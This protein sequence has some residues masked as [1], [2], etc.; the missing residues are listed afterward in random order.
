MA[1][2][3]SE[4]LSR[5]ALSGWRTPVTPEGCH[6]AHGRKSLAGELPHTH[7]GHAA[8]QAWPAHGLRDARVETSE[9]EASMP[10]QQESIAA[11]SARPAHA[12]RHA[13]TPD[14]LLELKVTQAP[15]DRQTCGRASIV[16]RADHSPTP[17]GH[18]TL[19]CV[20][21]MDGKAPQQTYSGLGMPTPK[22][23][24]VLQAES[25]LLPALAVNCCHSGPALASAP[26]AMVHADQHCC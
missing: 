14:W 4:A 26:L 8:C 11:W 3:V 21:P 7:R 20:M 6:S 25:R 12:A 24:Q 2:A 23:V 15:A 10:W 18:K 9:F 22:Q 16:S 17:A 19:V 13:D 5:L 1:S